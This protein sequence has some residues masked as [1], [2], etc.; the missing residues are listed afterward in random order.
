MMQTLNDYLKTDKKLLEDL[1]ITDIT[2]ID[3]AIQLSIAISLKRIA[4]SLNDNGS[5]IFNNV[6]EALNQHYHDKN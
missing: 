5:T 3:R 4:D 6:Y 2:A 1:V